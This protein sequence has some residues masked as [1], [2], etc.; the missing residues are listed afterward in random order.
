M[1]ASAGKCILKFLAVTAV[2]FGILKVKCYNFSIQRNESFQNLIMF[3]LWGKCFN[4]GDKNKQLV[5][6]WTQAIVWWLVCWFFIFI[7]FVQLTKNTN[8][9]IM[10]NHDIV[11]KYFIISLYIYFY[12]TLSD[13]I[14]RKSNAQLMS[15]SSMFHFIFIVQCVA[16]GFLYSTLFKSC[17]EVRKS[18]SS[19][20]CCCFVLFSCG[21][22]F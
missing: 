11:L 12:G 15:S 3:G 13:S 6:E 7:F 9:S 1:E 20:F 10:T 2:W 17:S 21:A 8:L 16:S 4:F 14:C 5:L 18:I 19:Q 22:L